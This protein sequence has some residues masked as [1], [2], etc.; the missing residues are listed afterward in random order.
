MN[1]RRLA[2]VGIV[3]CLVGL[4]VAGSVMAVSTG[5]SNRWFVIHDTIVDGQSVYRIE[6]R[7]TGVSFI[8]P[9][10]VS[11]VV[12]VRV[13]NGHSFAVSITNAR[14]T[15]TGLAGLRTALV[16]DLGST[17]SGPDLVPADT[18]DGPGQFHKIVHTVVDL[19]GLSTSSSFLITGSMTWTEVYS[20][21]ATAGPYTQPV[22]EV[23]T[24]AEVL[25][26]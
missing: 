5:I 3:L 26:G 19:T 16:F 14:F 25:G 2:A 10:T 8:G 21:G 9:N 6:A 17:P 23:H 13:F 20:N 12:H 18:A 24:I 4:V 7:L 15:V 22:A 11:A 1:A